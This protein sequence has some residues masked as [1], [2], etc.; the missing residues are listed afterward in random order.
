MLPLI[1]WNETI[2]IGIQSMDRQHHHWIDLMNELYDAMRTGKTKAVIGRTLMG[3]LEYTRTHFVSEEKL[4]T[5][6]GYPEYEEHEQ[7]HKDFIERIEELRHRQKSD[8]DALTT[9]VMS[10]LKEWLVNHIQKVDHQ[11]VFLL[12]SKGVR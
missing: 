2:A 5:T 4:L 12:K 10:I 7:M 9:E 8:N 1:I 6:Y 11:Y 3:M